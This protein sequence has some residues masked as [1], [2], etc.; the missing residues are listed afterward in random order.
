MFEDPDNGKLRWYHWWV[1]V[2]CAA[3]VLFVAVDSYGSAS[4]PGSDSTGKQPMVREDIPNEAWEKLTKDIAG[5]Q[6]DIQREL[7]RG[8]PEVGKR[9]KM[10]LVG[11]IN[12]KT[13]Y[14]DITILYI[15]DTWIK[16]KTHEGGVL[17]TPIHNITLL[18]EIE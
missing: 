12:N 13:D 4:V 5:L 9:Y 15:N 14:K 7:T 17:Y 11:F 16:F 3:A 6:G 8:M 2:A 18:E 10:R 1:I